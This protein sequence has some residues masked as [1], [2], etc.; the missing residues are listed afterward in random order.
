M[1]FY[2]MML[3]VTFVFIAS[4]LHICNRVQDFKLYEE[5]DTFIPAYIVVFVAS[6]LWFLVWPITIIGTICYLVFKVLDKV[7]LRKYLKK[8]KP[9]A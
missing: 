3:V 5:P 1:Q 9:D 7:F 8:D 6:V 4:I 2:L